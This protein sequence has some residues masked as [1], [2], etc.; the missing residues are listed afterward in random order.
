MFPDC[1]CNVFGDKP[2]LVIVVQSYSDPAGLKMWPSLA[3]LIIPVVGV[4]KGN[5]HRLRSASLDIAQKG[6]GG[7]IEV[8]SSM[9]RI[10]PSVT[11]TNMP[12]SIS[13]ISS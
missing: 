5:D 4:F 6:K 3:P 12:Y 7:T 13:S 10:F 2:E 8:H 1:G 9:V 11:V